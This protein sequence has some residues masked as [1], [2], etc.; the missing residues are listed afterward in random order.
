[1][2]R[3]AEKSDAFLD[4]MVNWQSLEGDMMKYAETEAANTKN[5]LEKAMAQVIGLEARKR[6]IIQQ[7]IVESVKKEAA[8]LDPEEIQSLVGHINHLLESEEKELPLAEAA[9]QKSELFI[10]RYL[11]NYL[12]ADLK[13]GN[14]LL[15]Q[16][17]DEL[18]A[19][20]I[21]TSVTS[22]IYESGPE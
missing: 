7:M 5:A 22:K 18:K 2:R 10:S 1:M 3:P 9:L 16:F 11:L 14:A 13:K 8:H 17:S 12:I 20:T 19:A 15:R 21:S 4:L 6:C